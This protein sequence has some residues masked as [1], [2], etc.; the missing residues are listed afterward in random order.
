MCTLLNRLLD[1]VA[2]HGATKDIDAKLILHLITLHKADADVVLPMFTLLDAIMTANSGETYAVCGAFEAVSCVVESLQLHKGDG[3][4]RAAAL[5]VLM[6]LANSNFIPELGEAV[7]GLCEVLVDVLGSNDA[8]L[9]LKC[10]INLFCHSDFRRVAHLQGLPG[11]VLDVTIGN[12]DGLLDGLLCLGNAVALADC[13]SSLLEKNVVPFCVEVLKTHSPEKPGPL[14]INLAA[15]RLLGSL[16]ANAAAH[17]SL[18]FHS[19][20]LSESWR[21]FPDDPAAA[22]IYASLFV[23]IA[24]GPVSYAVQLGRTVIPVAVHVVECFPENSPLLLRCVYIVENLC[25]ALPNQHSLVGPLGGVRSLVTV[26]RKNLNNVELSLLTWKLLGHL[27]RGDELVKS[28]AIRHGAQLYALEVLREHSGNSEIVRLYCQL[29]AL[30]AT[31]GE[32]HE[33]QLTQGLIPTVLDLARKYPWDGDVQEH[34]CEILT[35]ISSAPAFYHEMELRH[36]HPVLLQMLHALAAHPTSCA[37]TCHLLADLVSVCKPAFLVDIIRAGV[38]QP[39]SAAVGAHAANAVLCKDVNR[40]LCRFAVLPETMQRFLQQKGLGLLIQLMLA[41][42]NDCEHQTLACAAL[43]A[44]ARKAGPA[45]FALGGHAALVDALALHRSPVLIREVALALD[46]LAAGPD[47]TTQP[48]DWAFLVRCSRSAIPAICSAIH[49]LSHAPEPIIIYEGKLVPVRNTLHLLSRALAAIVHNQPID[50]GSVMPAAEPGTLFPGPF[51]MQAPA[52][53]LLCAGANGSS[54]SV[55]YEA[56]TKPVGMVKPMLPVFRAAPAENPPAVFSTGGGFQALS[57]ALAAQ[58]YRAT[59]DSFVQHCCSTMEIAIQAATQETHETFHESGIVVALLNIIATNPANADLATQCCKM[60]HFM[61]RFECCRLNPSVAAAAEGLLNSLTALAHDEEAQQWLNIAVGD[62]CANAAFLER[63]LSIGGMRGV[64]T[65]TSSS[66]QSTEGRAARGWAL[67]RVARSDY[68]LLH[69][70]RKLNAQKYIAYAADGSLREVLG[71]ANIHWC[72][73]LAAT[74][75]EFEEDVADE[76]A[77]ARRAIETRAETEWGRVSAAHS[78]ALRFIRKRSVVL[79]RA[80]LERLHMEREDQRG[81]ALHSI[82]LLQERTLAAEVRSQRA[83][84]AE[85]ELRCEVENVR[86]KLE[87]IAELE[88]Q[89]FP[90]HDSQ[91]TELTVSALADME[92]ELTTLR[93]DVRNLLDELESAAKVHKGCMTDIGASYLLEV[94]SRWQEISNTSRLV[95]EMES[96]LKSREEALATRFEEVVRREYDASERENA[97]AAAEKETAQQKELLD[98]EMREL[99]DKKDLLANDEAAVRKREQDVAAGEE[100]LAARV[101]VVSEREQLASEHETHLSGREDLFNNL[102]KHLGTVEARELQ[103]TL[104][105]Q[106]AAEREQREGSLEALQAEISSRETAVRDLEAAAFNRDAALSV[107]EKCVEVRE[108]AAD[109]REILLAKWDKRIELRRIEVEELW[110]EM[111]EREARALQIDE[112]MFKRE[113]DLEQWCIKLER[114]EED[115][116]QRDRQLTA[117]EDVMSQREDE[118]ERRELEMS[119]RETA[120]NLRELEGDEREKKQIARQQ[121]QDRRQQEQDAKELVL[122]QRHRD[123]ENRS[124]ELNELETNL[125]VKD[126]EVFKRE[127]EVEERDKYTRTQMKNMEATRSQMQRQQE[128]L[129]ALQ[130]KVV[131]REKDS[132]EI[133]SNLEEKERQLEVREM[134]VVQRERNNLQHDQEYDLKAKEQASR[135]RDLNTRERVVSKRET[136][137]ERRETELLNWMKEMQFREKE[138]E[139]GQQLLD[140]KPAGDKTASQRKFNESMLQVQLRHLKEEYVREKDRRNFKLKQQNTVSGDWGDIV[141]EAVDVSKVRELEQ[142]VVVQSKLFRKT[143]G[144][145]KTLRADADTAAAAS[146]ALSATEQAE[147]TA[148]QKKDEVLKGEIVFLAKLETCPLLT[149]ERFPTNELLVQALDSWWNSVYQRALQRKMEVLSERKRH[150]DLAGNLLQSKNITEKL[151]NFPALQAWQSEGNSGGD[152]ASFNAAPLASGNLTPSAFERL[153]AARPSAGGLR[154]RTQGGRPNSALSFDLKRRSPSASPY[155]NPQLAIKEKTRPKRA[156]KRE[157]APPATQKQQGDPPPSPPPLVVKRQGQAA[158]EKIASQAAQ[159]LAAVADDDDDDVD[160]APE[161]QDTT[162]KNSKDQ[163]NDSESENSQKSES[164]EEAGSDSKESSSKDSSGSRSGSASNSD[165]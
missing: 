4:I 45:I 153:T 81:E 129:E 121:A 14:A 128:S 86:D 22:Q 58:R 155:F 99:N 6:N 13:Q 87:F 60:L 65:S 165:D 94:D 151:P 117:R 82:I 88:L 119:Q 118:Q 9:G 1:K 159:L 7:V 132:A 112:E 140:K 92:T 29:L 126:R 91:Q 77:S 84:E 43:C 52:L 89:H 40:T 78:A 70:I 145:I 101:T 131:K 11:L 5:N 148:V 42:Q 46:Q 56:G 49:E 163:D 39:L 85:R 115:L 69:E 34:I 108:I 114:E 76:E 24:N 48:Q 107:R 143:L 106:R 8:L 57:L 124:A 161:S 15:A 27:A 66:G 20:T 130:L 127:K 109:K 71:D 150:L 144:V 100:S 120:M 136:E 162:S 134:D 47:E 30:F 146:A 160:D 35:N 16:S 64:L 18:V 25:R 104:R 61:F 3:T 50:T 80:T 157:T 68:N 53:K 123:A 32:C 79:S 10:A 133:S 90:Q 102:V 116:A 152:L 31:S 149:R 12:K 28:I 141:E 154:S 38:I 74:F 110:M 36:G 139:A 142:D 21:G 17:D 54:L 75:P 63:F 105:E 158:K 137:I 51:P 135:Q 62:A 103:V 111:E 83:A 138:L 72:R 23:N 122:E 55:V 96:D 125:R 93:R 156:K 2:A 97:V 44:V 33:L 113:I 95:H 98:V 41:L 164:D 26:L 19:Q 147:V 67:A 59:E 73:Q 37:A